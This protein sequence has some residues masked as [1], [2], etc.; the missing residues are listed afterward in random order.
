MLPVRPRCAWR[1]TSLLVATG[2]LATLVAVTAPL[3]PTV[4][5]AV[6]NPVEPGSAMSDITSAP[7]RPPLCTAEQ[8]AAVE[9]DDCALMFDGTPTDHGFPAPPFPGNQFILTP[10]TP[11]EWTPLTVGSAGPI[12][13]L[14][15][16]KLKATTP[17]I[18][19]DGKFGSQTA[20][21]V[22]KAQETLGL[23]QTGVVDAT[24]A[25]ALDILVRAEI[26]T[27]P[28][29]GFVWTG[30]DYN[31]SPALAEWEKRMVRGTVRTDPI[32]SALFEGFLADLRRGTFRID[33]AGTYAFRCTATSVRNCKGIGL[34]NLSYHAWGLAV[35]VNYTAN[36]LQTVYHSSDACSANVKMNI[37][38]WILKTAQHW[39]MFWGGWYSCPK[40]GQRSVVKD[41]HHFEFRGTP[42]TAAA[43]IAKNTAEGAARAWVPELEDLLLS[44]G[45]RGASVLRIRELLPAEYRP[46]EVASA[47]TTYTATLAAAVARWQTDNGLPATG[48]FDTATATALGLTVRHSEVFPV[49]HINSCGPAVK[50]LQTKLGITVTGTFGTTTM[51]TL[52][53][54]QI[55]N[56][57]P[58]TG[59]TDTRTSAAMGLRL[60]TPPPPPPPPTTDPGTSGDP[61][62]STSAPPVL[63]AAVPLGYGARSRSVSSLQRALTA[64]G[65]RTPVTGTFGPVT[66]RNLR[67]FQADNRLRLSSTLSI[68]AA[69]LLGLEPTPRL[70]VRLGQTGD[71]VRLVQQALR[72]RGVNLTVDGRFGPATRRAVIAFQRS[73]G[74]RVTAIVDSATARALGW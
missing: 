15:Q 6:A 10:L 66:L 73:A 2:L 13:T 11:E 1:R 54:W 48:A 17:L 55:A 3:S 5:T 32:A 20:T 70:P 4:P 37:P 35:D 8:I 74:L 64:K 30:N 34:S 24:T 7:V 44:C 29:E 28:P 67:A 46:T 14:L 42:E 43:I 25:A 21:A 57:V 19:Q 51:N 33:Q 65:Y 31:G 49:L 22:K 69:R 63:R 9:F 18:S 61:P 60:A 71:Q 40:S 26:G 12:V 72:D 59:V 16:E 23:S 38:D 47:Q 39:G 36:P 50:A 53:S 52:R 56:R 58:P 41:P 62:S 45:D 68:G 27:Y